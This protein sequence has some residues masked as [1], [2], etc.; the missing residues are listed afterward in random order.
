MN[1][2]VQSLLVHLVESDNFTEIV[3]TFTLGIKRS[4]NEDLQN[5]SPGQTIDFIDSM[6]MSVANM[7]ETNPHDIAKMNV[8]LSNAAGAFERQLS[9]TASHV[10]EITIQ[11]W[12]KYGMVALFA[13]QV[14]SDLQFIRMNGTLLGASIGGALFFLSMLIEAYVK[15][16]FSPLSTKHISGREPNNRPVLEP[17]KQ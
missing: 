13:E 6:R 15:T 8:E 11:L 12:E 5:D 17:P 16:S 3:A 10:I 7:L 2:T 4:L 1:H 14:G 9:D